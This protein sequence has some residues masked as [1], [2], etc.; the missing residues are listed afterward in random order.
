[1]VELDAC[2]ACELLWFDA[3]EVEKLRGLRGRGGLVPMPVGD[4]DAKAKPS[5]WVSA[6]GDILVEVLAEIVGGALFD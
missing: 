1:M 5:G 3:G 2:I 6:T 4:S